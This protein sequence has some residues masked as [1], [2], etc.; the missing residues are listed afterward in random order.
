MECIAIF[1]FH[2]N[3]LYI[4]KNKVLINFKVTVLLVKSDGNVLK[5]FKKRKTKSIF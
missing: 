1:D 4:V 3:V 2:I 5:F